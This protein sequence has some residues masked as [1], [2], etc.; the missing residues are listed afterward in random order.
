MKAVTVRYVVKPEAAEENAELVQAVYA[1]LAELQPEGFRYSTVRLDDGVT[2]IHTAIVEKGDAPL[3]G[4]ASFKRF[5]A[6]LAE[7]CAEQPVVTPGDVVG[8]YP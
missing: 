4:L 2:F 1:E 3:P 7:R 6:D 5:Q 8:R